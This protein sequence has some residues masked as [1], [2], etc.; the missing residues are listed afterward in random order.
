MGRK[1]V[2]EPA[3]K[4]RRKNGKRDPDKPRQKKTS[5]AA[6]QNRH[7][8]PQELRNFVEVYATRANFNATEA[9]MICGLATD[10]EY[11]GIMGSKLLRR[12]IVR[13]MLEQFQTGAL[14]ANFVQQAD[15]LRKLSDM[16]FFDIRSILYEDGTL[17]PISEWPV[18]AGA[19][20]S[21]M[22]IR[23]IDLGDE[24]QGKIIKLRLR[25]NTKPLEMLGKHIGMFIEK[26]IVELNARK[27]LSDLL[28]EIADDE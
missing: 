23:Q 2:T 22:E 17:R 18:A 26:K 19:S 25:D 11:A 13:D 27:P 9:V 12:P 20:V 10:R 28:A 4:P 15:I 5:L 14:E 8:T 1:A 6:R 24:S 3:A 21:G 7:Y 16:A